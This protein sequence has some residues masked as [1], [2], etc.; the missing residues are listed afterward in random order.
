M[1][2]QDE[3]VKPGK[4]IKAKRGTGILSEKGTSKNFAGYSKVFKGPQNKGRVA[5]ISGVKPRLPKPSK[6]SSLARRA[7]KGVQAT[8]LGKKLLPVVAAGVAAQQYLKSKMKKKKEMKGD[9]KGSTAPYKKMGGGMMKVRGY[10]IGSPRSPE[11]RR[12][13]RGAQQ[14]RPTRGAGLGALGRTGKKE[15]SSVTLGKF[16]AAKTKALNESVK[17]GGMKKER[18]TQGSNMR[19]PEAFVRDVEAGKYSK[20]NKDAFYY[21]SIGLTGERGDSAV[22]K[23]FAPNK[24]GGGMMMKPMGYKSGKSIK[25]KCKLG[26]NKPTKMY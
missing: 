17:A 2:L 16:M 25:V 19:R 4:V 11:R 26:K 14:A 20:P 9:V 6:E 18:I 23:F 1:G 15:D 8:S 5:T 21:K 7:L 3:K 10:A 24:M 12:R 22:K 13:S